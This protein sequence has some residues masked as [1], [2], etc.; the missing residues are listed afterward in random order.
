MAR[1]ED[2]LEQAKTLLR[3][4]KYREACELFSEIRQSAKNLRPDQNEDLLYH[5]S[6][7][8]I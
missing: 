7:I 3:E 1:V 8:H 6:L 2:S 4:G 5:L